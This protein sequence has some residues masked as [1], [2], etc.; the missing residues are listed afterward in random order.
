YVRFG[1]ERGVYFFSLNTNRRLVS[2]GGRAASLPFRQTPMRI[3]EENDRLL[4]RGDPLPAGQKGML[5]GTYQPF[6]AIFRQIIGSLSY[7]LYE[8]Y[9]ICMSRNNHNVKVHI[10]QKQWTLQQAYMNIHE[11]QNIH[12]TYDTFSHYC[13]Y[14][15]S[16]VYP[17]E[18][19]GIIS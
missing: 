16:V 2:A 11:I 7:F 12:F 8:R 3:R 5:Q 9:C 13:D 14:L 15:P 4:F 6:S 1:N 17:F 18:N 19:I 10:N